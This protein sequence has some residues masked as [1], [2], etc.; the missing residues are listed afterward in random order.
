MN[1][2]PSQTNAQGQR[3]LSINAQEV[4]ALPTPEQKLK[5]FLRS[6]GNG[7]DT[8]YDYVTPEEKRK[9]FLNFHREFVARASA[10]AV[11]QAAK[12]SPEQAK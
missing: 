10:L 7:Q 4:A 2:L 1:F 9:N 6:R 5:T 3:P 8:Y 11:P 12:A